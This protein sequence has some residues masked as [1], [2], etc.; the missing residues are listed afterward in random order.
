MDLKNKAIYDYHGD[1][2]SSEVSMLDLLKGD[3]I[4]RDSFRT[5]AG[6]LDNRHS[7][8]IRVLN[9]ADY[10]AVVGNMVMNPKLYKKKDDV[11][12]IGLYTYKGIGSG[13]TRV[14][15]RSGEVPEYIESLMVDYDDGGVNMMEIAQRF[16]DYNIIIY[17]TTSDSGGVKFRLLLDLRRPMHR[18]V[19]TYKPNQHKLLEMFEGC[20]KTTF[21]WHRFFHVPALVEDS[22]KYSFVVHMG[23]KQFSL[24]NDAGLTEDIGEYQYRKPKETTERESRESGY[25]MM[26]KADGNAT[27]REAIERAT[28]EI[29]E[30]APYM[31]Q[32]GGGYDLHGHML[33][34][35][36]IFQDAGLN[37]TEAW[38]IFEAELLPHSYTKSLL[39]DVFK[40]FKRMFPDE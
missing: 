18:D 1:D 34:A 24:I 21:N 10:F 16:F 8:K 36:T 9:D 35:A 12:L 3:L 2:I 27:Y 29:L 23:G 30:I 15:N 33:K 14:I 28:E 37:S 31:D 4:G 13:Q 6:L 40:E 22:Q 20:D 19:F 32:R 17:S 7:T 39:N 5:G 38:S 25:S 11:P 26:G